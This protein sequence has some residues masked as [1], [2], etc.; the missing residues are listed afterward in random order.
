MSFLITNWGHW[1]S[2]ENKNAGNAFLYTNS[3]D[4]LATITTS[5]YFNDVITRLTVG[6]LIYIQ[7][8]DGKKVVEVTSVTTNV[9]VQNLGAV[10]LK[11]I[12]GEIYTTVGGA[13]AEVITVTGALATD[14]VVATLHTK[15]ATPRI[16]VTAATGTDAVT[17]TFDGDPSTDHLVNYVVYRAL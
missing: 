3:A 12:A 6:D 5:A 10:T 17:V 4:T 13:A 15:G 9:T 7:G 14:I 11:V 8:S 16:I 2:T 1:A